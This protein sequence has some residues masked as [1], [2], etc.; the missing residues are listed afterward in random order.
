[1]QALPACKRFG[2]RR[3]ASTDSPANGSGHGVVASE[4][5][6]VI[7][8]KRALCAPCM[9]LIESRDRVGEEQLGT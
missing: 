9:R 8:G 3:A 5:G 7:M 2:V 4:L 6:C 1:M